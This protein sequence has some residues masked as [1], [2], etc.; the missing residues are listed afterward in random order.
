M[1]QMK[2]LKHICCKHLKVQYDH[3]KQ[4]LFYDRTIHDGHGESI[5]GL[6]VCKS[7]SLPQD[8][9]ERCFAES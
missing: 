8:F 2:E 1:K 4:Q 3:E 5:Y 7:M 6:E 9:M